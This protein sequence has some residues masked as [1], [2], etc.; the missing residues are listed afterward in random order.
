MLRFSIIVPCYRSNATLAACLESLAQ[1]RFRSFE[2]ILVDSTPSDESSRD[3]AAPYPWVIYHYS[4]VRLGAHAARNV[5]AQFARGELL[6]FIDPDMTANA[7]WLQRLDAEQRSGHTVLAGGVDCP[8]GYWPQAVHL[9]KYGWWLSGGPAKK[10]SQLP[11]GNLCL[12]RALFQ[13][14][15]GFP[16]RFWEGDTALSYAIA[17]KGI[18][19]WQQPLAIAVHHDVPNLRGFL[20]E[21]RL[22]GLDTALARRHRLRWGLSERVLRSLAAP[23]VWLLMLFRGAGFAF[24]SGWGWRWV[25]SSPVIGIG[26]AFWVAGECQG[27]WEPQ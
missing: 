5:A 27:Y 18:E 24:D 8:A 13:E 4:P 2:V 21:R 22:R 19:L 14:L 11:S 20:Q 9:T 15:G 3:L 25:L 23:L 6:A 16:D 26:L 7:D 1:Q 10:H 17:S 12:P